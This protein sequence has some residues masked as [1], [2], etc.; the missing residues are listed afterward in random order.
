MNEIQTKLAQLQEKGWTLAAIADELEITVNALDKWKAG[1]R[2]PNNAKAIFILIDQLLERKRIPKMKRYVVGSRIKLIIKDDGEMQLG[3]SKDIIPSIGTESGIT[4]SESLPTYIARKW[5]FPLQ[6]HEVNATTFYSIKDWIAGLTG[7]NN[8]ASDI[9]RDYQRRLGNDVG[10]VSNP[11]PYRTLEG[12]TIQMDFTND[13]GLYKLAV[14]LRATK[15]RPLLRAINDFLAKSGVFVDEARRDPEAASEKL[16]I[17]R[18]AKAIQ[19]GK[20]EDWIVTREQSVIT[21][22]QFVNS[23]Y[24][25]V[26]NKEAFGAIIGAITN[27]EYRGVF[28]ADVAGLRNRLGITSKEN[29]RDH[30]SRIALAYTTIAEES[31]RIHLNNHNDKDF[32]PVYVIQ[33]VVRTLSA[34]IGVQAKLIANALGVDI[35]TGQ[36]LVEGQ[37]KQGKL[38]DILNNTSP[39]RLPS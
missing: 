18:R 37:E 16:A 21:R 5:G 12:R 35:V 27:D 4:S 29:P 7:T 11:L 20:T 15:A 39:K 14:S 17:E 34:A 10:M 28:A 26:Q 38:G 24:G 25:L 30:F 8:K 23:I 13:E 19:A 32:V 33:D 2:F 36:K 1:D 22:K 9:W 3:N 6:K 31:I